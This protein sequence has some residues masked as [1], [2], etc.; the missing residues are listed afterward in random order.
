MSL[1][2]LLEKS[3]KGA[4]VRRRTDRPKKTLFQLMNEASERAAALR[5]RNQA[6]WT[7]PA[8]GVWKYREPVTARA[9]AKVDAIRDRALSLGWSEARLYQNRA[10]FRFP[11]GEDYGLV[12]FMDGVQQIGSITTEFIEIIHR[13]QQPSR[14]SFYFSLEGRKSP[15]PDQRWES[16]RLCVWEDIRHWVMK[17]YV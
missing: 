4:T 9:L 14:G 10:R 13:T 5:H 1:M 12:C 15:D 2:E 3:E 7:Y 6:D 11:C 17:G 16:H 8:D